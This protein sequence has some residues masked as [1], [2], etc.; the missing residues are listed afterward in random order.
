ME[1]RRAAEKDNRRQDPR[2]NMGERVTVTFSAGEMVGSGQNISAQGVFFV[3]ETSIPVMVRI[4]GVAAPVA[5]ELIRV[6]AMGEGKL[7]IAVRF[8]LPDQPPDDS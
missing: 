1:R 3:A 7:G 6:Q 4:D 5:G 8:L 2:V